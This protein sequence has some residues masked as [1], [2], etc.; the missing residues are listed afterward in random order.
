M[1]SV[2]KQPEPDYQTRQ[3]WELQ[4]EIAETWREIGDCRK[5][6]EQNLLTEQDLASLDKKYIKHY[7]NEIR[8]LRRKLDLAELKRRESLNKHDTQNRGN[9]NHGWKCGLV[10]GAIIGLMV[11]QWL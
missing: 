4:D 2:K 8:L 9:F 7:T 5:E 1:S 3:L 11:G 6:V 10:V